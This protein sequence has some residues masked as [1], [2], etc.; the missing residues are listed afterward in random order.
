MQFVQQSKMLAVSFFVDSIP[1][2]IVFLECMSTCVHENDNPF[3]LPSSVKICDEEAKKDV[4]KLKSCLENKGSIIT[5]TCI[6]ECGDYEEVNGQVQKMT[7]DMAPN[8]H[9]AE[10]AAKVL[11]K[12]SDACKILKCSSRCSVQEYNEECDD[13]AN[14]LGAGDLIQSLIEG[15]LKATRSD[16]EK[17][18]LVD[19]LAHS[20]PAE[21]NYMWALKVY[22]C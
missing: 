22:L 10:K 4:E 8:P 17:H 2:E 18:D 12:T 11:E 3:M 20:V 15:V 19:V 5:K 21:C 7:M 16:L 6:D 13:I 9:D 1:I 14:D